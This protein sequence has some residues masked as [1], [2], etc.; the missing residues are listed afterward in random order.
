[1]GKFIIGIAIIIALS[2][3]S[4]YDRAN[5]INDVSG[6]SDDDL[7]WPPLPGVYRNRSY[8]IRKKGMT[9]WT[10]LGLGY[11]FTKPFRRVRIRALLYEWIARWLSV[12]SAL[13]III[14]VSVYLALGD[15]PREVLKIAFGYSILTALP[16]VILNI[17]MDEHSGI[18]KYVNRLI[19][20]FD[21]AIL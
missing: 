2:V 15:I 8:Y 19:D 12:I 11:R 17:V 21:R 14:L 18:D 7:T 6:M 13:V 16:M 3:S 1:M 9:E 4:Y 5:L 10:K 20:R